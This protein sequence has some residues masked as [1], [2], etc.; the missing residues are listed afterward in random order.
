MNHDFFSDEEL[1]RMFDDPRQEPAT[2]P[3]SAAAIVPQPE[4]VPLYSLALAH[5]QPAQPQ[6]AQPVGAAPQSAAQQAPNGLLKKKMGPLPLWAW[7]VMALGVGGTGF[8]AWKSMKKNPSSS[9]SEGSSESPKIGEIIS[10]ALTGGGS[11]SSSS[12]EPSRSRFADQLNRYFSRK[13]Q[14][15]HVKVWHDAEEAQASGMKHLS[16]LINVQV[17]HGTVKLDQALT[18]FCRREGLNPVEHPDGSIGLYPHNS[19]RG[20]EWEEYID[21]LRDDGQKI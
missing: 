13:G 18:R 21:A 5:Q 2:A 8:F 7:G 16:P 10:K 19:K 14:S 4:P 9:D 3:R 6:V 12:W 20:K 15:Q 1:D 17:K 11:S